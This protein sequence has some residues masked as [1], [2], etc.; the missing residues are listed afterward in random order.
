MG[1]KGGGVESTKGSTGPYKGRLQIWL[2]DRTRTNVTVLDEIGI[3]GLINV[4][5]AVLGTLQNSVQVM[6]K[7]MTVAAKPHISRQC[8]GHYKGNGKARDN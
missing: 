6:A 5:I 3:K 2:L 1:T 4:N 7:C 8:E